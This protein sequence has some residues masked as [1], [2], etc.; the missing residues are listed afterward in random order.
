M[1]QSEILNFMKQKKNPVLKSELMNLGFSKPAINRSLSKLQKY[2][3]INSIK[4]S[5]K[6]SI[7]FL[8]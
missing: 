6:P 2:C 4:K 7:Y 3:F 1:S 8:K 5:R